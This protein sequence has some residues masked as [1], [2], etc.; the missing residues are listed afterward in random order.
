MS[1]IF[2]TQG[3]FE[4]QNE[5]IRQGTPVRCNIVFGGHNNATATEFWT[6][7]AGPIARGHR[8]CWT[9][10]TSSLVP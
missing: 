9:S 5:C 4:V 2:S 7:Q 1:N 8:H 10:R 3:T 6:I